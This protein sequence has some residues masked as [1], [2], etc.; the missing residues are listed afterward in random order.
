MKNALQIREVTKTFRTGPRKRIKITAV[1]NI[2]LEVPEGEIFG[3]LG[4]NGAGKSTTIRLMLGLLSPDAGEIFIG[5]NCV[6]TAKKAALK[7]VGALVEGPAF[8]PYLS[9]RENLEVFAAYTEGVEKTRIEE[10]INI[11]GLQGREK[12]RV[13]A[14][15]MG[16]KQ[17]LGIAQALLNRPDLLV[18]DEPTNGLDPHGMKDIRKLLQ[19]LSREHGTTVFLSSHI[20]HEV[21]QTCDRVAVINRGKI[22]AEGSVADLLS[23]AKGIYEIRTPD[24]GRVTEYIERKT[25]CRLVEKSPLRIEMRDY[26]PESLVRELVEQHFPITAFTP[27][28]MTLEDF[29]LKSAPKGIQV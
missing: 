4:P 29:F 26:R 22:V 7:K 14:Y 6:Q 13:S 17:R 21:Q 3:F 19:N 24:P 28:A 18:L 5:D 12:E 9:G 8:Y 1:D 2:S 20:L 23:S 15:S 10:V 25:S 27:V 16:M 11:V